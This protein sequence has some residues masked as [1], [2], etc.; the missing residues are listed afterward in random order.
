MPREGVGAEHPLNDRAQLVFMLVFLAV[1]AVDTFFLHYALSMTGLWALFATV[2][3]G[4]ALF[5]VGIYFIRKSEAVVFSNTEGKVIDSGVYGRVR[6]P[7]Y[8]GG[9]WLLLGFAVATLSIL[10]FVVWVVF[11]VFMDRMA[12]YEEN[13]LARLLG[14]QYVDYRKRVHKWIPT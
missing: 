14:Q 1:W 10:A 4:V 12:A 8:F 5:V 2:P 13:D 6:H 7:M 11:F 3:A 9:L